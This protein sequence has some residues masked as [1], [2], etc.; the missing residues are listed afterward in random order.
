MA[1]KLQIGKK[2]GFVNRK[3]CFYCLELNNK[4]VINQHIQSETCVQLDFTI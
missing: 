2:L 4:A 3:D 1:G